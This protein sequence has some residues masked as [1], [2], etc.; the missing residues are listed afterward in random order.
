MSFI[1]PKLNSLKVTFIVLT[2]L[3]LFSAMPFFMGPGL[4]APKTIGPYANNVFPLGAS[5]VLDATYRVAYPNVTFFYP[6]TFK[7]VPNQDKIIIGQL[8]GVIYWLDND[9]TTV[10]K[11]LLLDISNEVGLVSDG[12]FLGL[13]IHPDFDAP[14]NPKNYFYTYYATKN[15]NGEDLPGFGQYTGQ[16]CAYSENEHQGNFLILERFEVDPTTMTVVANSRTTLLKNRL[17]GTTHYGGG[18]DFGDDGFLYLTTGDQA[19]W[20]R[21]QDIINNLDGGLLRIDVD[22]DPT[23]SHPPVRT[24]PT[25]A[26]EADEISGLEYWIPNDNPFSDTTAGS[27]TNLYGAPILETADPNDVYAV[28]DF[29]EEYY[30]IGLRNPFRMTKDKNT[31]D[32]YI[33]DVGLNT[34]EEINVVQ[35]AA[36]FGWPLFE[37]LINGPGCYS[38]L[39]N[40]MPHAEPLVAFSPEDANSITGGFVYRGTEIPELYGKYICADFGSGDEIYSVETSTG[41]YNQISTFLPKDIISFGE[42]NDGELYLLRLGNATNIYKLIDDDE[43]FDP[44]PH[45]LSETGVFSDLSTLEVIDGFVPYEL[46]ESFWSDGALKRRWIAVPNNDGV[47]NGPDEQINYSEYDDWEFPKGTVIIKHFDLQTDDND[48]SVTRKIETR[49]S[50]MGDEGQ[51]YFLTYNWNEDETDAVLQSTSL[52]EPIDI[53]TDTGGT[54]TQTWHFPSN[55]ECT[56]CH[57]DANKGGL[58]L[59]SRFL[60][61]DYTYDET[62]ITGN[63]LVTLSHLGIIN[64]SITDADTP[65]IITNKSLYDANASI[66]EKARS[67]MDLN[68]AYCHRFDNENRA[69]FDLRVYN[70]LEATNLLTAGIL[71]PL[72][73]DPDEE[74][75]F[76]GDASKSILFHR[77][78]SIDPSIMMPPLSKSIIDQPAVDLIDEWINQLDEPDTDTT[79]D[80]NPFVNLALI[81]SAQLS[82]SVDPGSGRGTPIDILYDPLVGDF[83]VITNY[84]EYGEPFNFNSGAVDAENGFY[85]RVDWPNPRFINY[86]TFG[87]AFA[88]QPQINTAWRVSYLND[89]NWLTIDEGIGGWINGGIFQWDG[90]N[91][92]PLFAEA[93][94]VQLFSDGS[95]DMIGIHLRGRGGS[96]QL[97]GDDVPTEPKASLVQFL[98]FD[99]LTRIA[100]VTAD[101]QT[102]N[103]SNNTYS[104]DLIVSYT[105][106]PTTGNLIVNG[107]TFPITNSPQTITL[108]GLTPNGSD[109]TVDAAFTDGYK[110]D[111]ISNGSVFTAPTECSILIE[112]PTPL[113]GLDIFSN[114]LDQ[115]VIKGKLESETNYSLF[116][117]NGR[118]ITSNDLNFSSTDQHIDT[119]YLSTGVYILQLLSENNDRRIEKLVIH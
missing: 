58:G 60:N 95:N 106:Q 74:I 50:V 69:N 91:T 82:G 26:G 27:N 97:G 54:R 22:K 81:H 109:V 29:F 5:V 35:S 4:N 83:K 48:P 118:L 63:Q 99:A 47:H 112:N 8:N 116:D 33:G 6:I 52:D 17:Y 9:E 87:G 32:F 15:E 23:K 89:G 107:E 113:S 55:S 11:N 53:I 117:I 39:F 92:A 56:T 85:W 51:M 104:Q 115:I 86:V 24:K 20:Q 65:G 84:A 42:D 98:P 62:G 36:N 114:N 119:S 38:D 7:P 31:G 110:S 12:G 37:G 77:M 76:A 80:P 105:N 73:I 100:S 61:T 101:L 72:F 66:D 49:F 46:Y 68:C 94:R 90:S 3:L 1:R 57:N 41:E 78:N 13:T 44:V 25:D 75:V 30:T 2:S 103:A 21:S 102:C 59:K 64:A 19:S 79:D 88:N 16:G 10:N 34:H 43:N 28:G 40:E 70:S 18:L 111:Y 93:L 45:L 71:E 14:T 108:S 96:T 67:Y